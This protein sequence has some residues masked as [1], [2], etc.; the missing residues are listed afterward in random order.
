M[1]HV[2][3]KFHELIAAEL[4][5]FVGIEL[6]EEC[7]GVG[8]P[9]RTKTAPRPSARTTA[10]FTPS[11]THGLTGLLAFVVAKLSVAIGVEFFDHAFAHFRPT[12]RNFARGS[13]FL[14][15]N[16]TGQQARGH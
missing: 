7:I 9:A 1:A 2:L 6:I 14:C 16:H 8:R 13:F 4:A 11:F 12:Q 10:S 15:P 3:G 5:I